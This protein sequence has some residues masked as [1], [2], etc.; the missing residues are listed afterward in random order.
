MLSNDETRHLILEILYRHAREKGTR[1]GLRL[2]QIQKMLNI[3][4]NL[5]I[6]NL[7]YLDQK[8]LITMKRLASGWEN[9]SISAYGIDVI[10]RKDEF[11]DKFPFIQTTIQE[12]HGD[13]YGT[14][15][16]GVSSQII[17]N[18]QL[19]D[20]FQ[21]AR[22]ITEMKQDISSEDREKINENLDSLED[23]LKK[24]ESDAGKIQ[25]TWKWLKRNANWVVPI[26]TQV[27]LEGLKRSLG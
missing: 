1:I 6:F 27:V 24:E 22:K 25:R 21:Q 18:L 19:V 8:G 17:F 3:P 26:L 13:V 16:Q 7:E 5:V 2:D 23:E 4:D 11:R 12:I 20:A 15:I 9:I 14:V 10:E